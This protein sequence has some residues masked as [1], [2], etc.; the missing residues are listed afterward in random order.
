MSSCF[1]LWKWRW[2]EDVVR[3]PKLPMG[4]KC[5]AL[6]LMTHHNTKTGDLFPS[7]QTIAGYLGL[8]TRSV[9]TSLTAL[10]A[11]GLVATKRT[12]ISGSLRYTLLK[13]D[14]SGRPLK[15]EEFASSV[16]KPASDKPMNQPKKRTTELHED[17]ALIETPFQQKTL[18]SDAESMALIKKAV[19]DAMGDSQGMQF[20]YDL[21]R[22]NQ[23][24][25]IRRVQDAEEPRDVIH[26]IQERA[27]TGRRCS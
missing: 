11:A 17:D 7:Q 1:P 8:T 21:S 12:T 4:A 10:K 27:S 25:I 23:I 26:D 19:C 9:R 16:R 13:S 3:D 2:V 6:I 18:K 15:A 24:E 22:D 5:V 20:L 14:G